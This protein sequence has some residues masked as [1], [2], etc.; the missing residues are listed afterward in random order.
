MKSS[1]KNQ[2]IAL[3][4]QGL[5]YS[6]ILKQIPVAK[7]TLSVWF[8]DVGL[9]KKQKQLITEK[10]IAGRLRGIES[11]KR[12]KIKRIKDI[13]DLAKSEVPL[14]IQDPFWLTGVILYWCEGAKER[15]DACRIKFTNMDLQMHKLFLMWVRKYLPIREDTLFFELF[16][17]EKANIEKAM[18]YWMQNLSFSEDKLRVYFKK[19]NPKTKRKNIGGEY[20]GV[21]SLRINQSI[22]LNRKI[23]GW[24]E[25]VALYLNQNI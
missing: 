2:A 4:K 11:I 3:R 14:L 22:P 18:R 12:N 13:K 16:I 8:V 20:C 17:H 5:S 23:A 15:T 19:H 25:G 10:R 6:E 9:A 7:S 21:L 1:F 24:T